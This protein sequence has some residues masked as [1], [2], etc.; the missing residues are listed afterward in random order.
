MLVLLLEFGL[1][2]RKGAGDTAKQGENQQMHR[3][4]EYVYLRWHRMI[5]ICGPQLLVLRN[6]AELGG[7][8]L[9][10]AQ[11][12]THAWEGCRPLI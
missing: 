3:E 12:D 1:L 6:D 4:L 7:Q 5:A 9:E 2:E 10:V 8:I 11:A